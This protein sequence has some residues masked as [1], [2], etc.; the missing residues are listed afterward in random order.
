MSRL[1]VVDY[2]EK[3][4][5]PMVYLIAEDELPSFLQKNQEKD[6]MIM[7]AVQSI[8]EGNIISK[9]PYRNYS[10]LS[11]RNGLLCKGGRVVI[12]P[13]VTQDL[14]RQYHGQAHVGAENTWLALSGRFYWRR[15]KQQ[16]ESFVKDCRSC[17]QCKHGVKPKAAVQ[18]NKEVKQFEMLAIDIASMP[19][20]YDGNCCF[21]LMVDSFS[22][23][24]AAAALPNQRARSIIRALWTHWFG[25]FGLPKYMIS[26]QGNNV[27]GAEIQAMCT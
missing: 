12:P 11:I 13:T 19:I 25:Y 27:N 24:A 17:M 1:D 23:L 8:K 22:K 15:M 3:L 4:E 16:V 20:S 26:D 7:H 2:T 18:N 21:L 9:G 14:I 5:P 6:P 10:N